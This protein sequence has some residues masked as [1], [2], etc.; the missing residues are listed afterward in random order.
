MKRFFITLMGLLAFLPMTFGAYFTNVPQVRVQPNGDTLHCFATGDE[1]FHRLHDA[2]GYTIV[3][4]PA[5]G[6]YVYADKVGDALV[7][8]VHIAGRVNPAEVGLAPNL[9]I[10]AAQWR[11]RRARM[12]APARSRAGVRDFEP[13][14]GHINNIVIFIRFADDAPFVNDFGSV[15]SM[16]N[17]STPGYSSMYNY[18]K[19]AT[20]NQLSITSTFYPEQTG[21]TILSYQDMYERGYFEPYSAENPDGYDPDDNYDRTERE[22]SLLAR[23][24]NAVS[25]QIP[26]SLDI[27]YNG[28]G[29]VDNVV[30]VVRGNVGD[31]NDLLWPHRWALYN[32]SAYINDKRV[33]D[34]NLQ[35]ADAT[36]YFNTSVL[37]HEMNHSLG[38]PDLYHYYEGTDLS[39][40]GSWDLMEQTLNPPQHMGA[41][42][43]YKYGHWID[44]IPE[45]TVCGNYSLHS[46]GSSATNNCYRIA[47]PHPNEFFVLEYRN[48]NDLFEGNLPASGLLIYRI[49]TDFDGNASYDGITVF[50]EVYLY[51]RNGTPTTNGYLPSAA[52]SADAG[53]T[54]MNATTNPQPFLTDGTVV[55]VGDFTIRNISETG[56]EVMTFTFCNMDYLQVTP[57]ELILDMDSAAAG[58]VHVSSDMSWTITGEDCDWLSYTPVSDSGAVDLQ[59]IA[60]SENLTFES[61]ICTLTV[62]ASN[63]TQQTLTITQRGQEPYLTAQIIEPVSGNV[64]IFYH[65][66]S[67]C[68]IEL[69]SN[70]AWTISTEADWIGLS[71]TEGSGSAFLTATALTENVACVPRYATIVA[72]NEYGQTVWMSVM[73]YNF[74]QGYLSITPTDLTID[75]YMGASAQLMV[76]SSDTWNVLSS[77]SWLSVSPVTGG[78]YDNAVNLEVTGTNSAMSPRIGYV[79]ISD[80]CG[81]TDS[82]IHITITQPEGYL[83]LSTES[84]EVG[85]QGSTATLGLQCHSTWL[86]TAT[87]VPEWLSVTPSSGNGNAEITVMAISDNPE[88]EPRTSVVRFRHSLNLYVELLVTQQAGTGIVEIGEVSA[89]LYP[90]PVADVLTV[91]L[92]GSFLYTVYD[93]SGRMV[94]QG[95]LSANDN[96]LSVSNLESGIYYIRLSEE[97]TG[98]TTVAKFVKR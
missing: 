75:N 11:E 51:R 23:A 42:M 14:Q 60:L 93:A 96:A 55:D 67:T 2:A 46:L 17:D 64:G 85:P 18:F 73:Q 98:K 32:T 40:V 45:I 77:P 95:H 1:Y 86:V 89:N 71:Q 12:E 39:A 38:A 81:R 44:S 36:S 31:W 62:T 4:D 19:A 28:D 79:V 92:E 24:V 91:D 47:S 21:G 87:S 53:R 70:V 20:Y 88:S 94:M 15:Q 26:A 80:I 29:Y 66:N 63:G 68:S 59:V 6:Y 56:G 9:S 74:Y 78:A 50:D 65:Q 83:T 35:L 7:P 76:T 69:H 57:N 58:S 82:E 10:S 33:W 25:S 48:R 34:F 97:Q 3:L 5:T 13:N 27:D 61:R 49:N 30:F 43:K 8:T 72:T 41:Y 90:N 52:F 37:C 22:H 54:V 84:V 16:F